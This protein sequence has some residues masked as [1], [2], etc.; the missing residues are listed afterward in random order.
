MKILIICTGNSCRSQMAEGFLRSFDLRLE[1]YSAGTKPEK[2]VNPFAVSVMKES[3]I[4]ISRQRP[5][6]IAVF[7]N[8]NFDIVITVCDHAKE[9]CPVFTGK[10]NK[11]IHIGFTDPADA[12]G[13][14]DEILNVY[15]TIRDQIK[16]DFYIFYKQINNGQLTIDNYINT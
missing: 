13:T 11:Q 9:I 1:V 6:H 10:V 3:F 7:Q 15:R 2:E 14:D 4:D 12:T 8:E 5:S 16:N